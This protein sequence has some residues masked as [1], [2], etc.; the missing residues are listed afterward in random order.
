MKKQPAPAWSR[1]AGQEFAKLCFL[2]RFVKLCF[3]N[4]DRGMISVIIKKDGTGNGSS[5]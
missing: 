5:L 4:L 3:P 2:C 1:R